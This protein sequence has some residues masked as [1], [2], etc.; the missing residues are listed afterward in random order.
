MSVGDLL[1]KQGLVDL[2]RL[3]GKN[4]NYEA[5]ELARMEIQN[6]YRAPEIQMNLNKDLKTITINDYNGNRETWEIADYL[7]R[8][9]DI[10]KLRARI[11]KIKDKYMMENRYE[12]KETGEYFLRKSVGKNTGMDNIISIMKD[13][14]ATRYEH[15]DGQDYRSWSKVEE[16]GANIAELRKLKFDSYV[17]QRNMVELSGIAMEEAQRIVNNR[18]KKKAF[19]TKEEREQYRNE[20]IQKEYNRLNKSYFDENGNFIY[21]FKSQGEELRFYKRLSNMVTDLMYDDYPEEF[22]G[23]FSKIA[24]KEDVGEMSTKQYWESLSYN[25]KVNVMRFHYSEDTDIKLKVL[26][27]EGNKEELKKMREIRKA[28]NRR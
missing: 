21:T 15:V 3:R 20:Q 16:A 11:D 18:M 7:K 28:L 17:D 23:L 19:W 12:Y 4:V 14:I 6:R 9:R 26:K 13:K 24:E 1:N 22:A 8:A 2:R 27:E 10:D 25:E 5:I